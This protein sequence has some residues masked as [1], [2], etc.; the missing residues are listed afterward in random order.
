MVYSPRVRDRAC[1]LRAEERPRG[2]VLVVVVREAQVVVEADDVERVGNALLVV[3][4]HGGG[5]HPRGVQFVAAL[6]H[7]GGNL[8]ALFRHCVLKLPLLVAHRPQNHA[9]RVAIALDHGGKLRQALGA[10]THLPGLAHHHHAH[11]VAAVDPLRRGHVVRG[12]HG[13]AAHLLEHRQTV[14]LQRVGNGCAHAGMVLMIAGSLNL[15]RLAV[16][17]KALFGYPSG[18]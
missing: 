3:A 6:H 14:P 16:E 1:R 15:H 11:A 13:V 12:A 18:R 9:G 2:I 8:R 17:E 7:G 5:H 4:I 10:G